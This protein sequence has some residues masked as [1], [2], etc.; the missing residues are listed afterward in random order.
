MLTIYKSVLLMFF[1]TIIMSCAV[2]GLSVNRLRPGEDPGRKNDLSNYQYIVSN[3]VTNILGTELAR[4]EDPD[5]DDRGNGTLRLPRLSY[6]GVY[7]IHETVIS[8]DAD[9]VY[10]YLAFQERQYGSAA[11]AT[12]SAGGFLRTFVGVYFDKD[13]TADGNPSL[14]F[15][16][17]ADGTQSQLDTRVDGSDIYV[18]YAVGIVGNTYPIGGTLIDAYDSG[19]GTIKTGPI[20]TNVEFIPTSFNYPYVS[21]VFAFKVPRGSWLT[22]GAW[23]ILIFSYNWEDYGLTTCYPGNNGHLRENTGSTP[24]EYAFGSTSGESASAIVLMAD[25]VSEDTNLMTSIFTTKQVSAADFI[26]V[27]LP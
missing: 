8:A 1:A 23:K 20:L 7:D 14:Q 24:T 19:A 2:E 11:Q 16:A 6:V 3:Y 17:P 4:I 13:G 21:T 22:A 9:Y 27:T 12:T 26:D 5:G 25:V 18:D 10:F 15:F